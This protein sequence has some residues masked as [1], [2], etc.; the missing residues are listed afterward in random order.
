MR[1]HDL[2]YLHPD[3]AFTTPCAAAGS[4]FWLAARQWIAQGRPLVAA[5]QPAGGGPFCLGLALPLHQ[6]R[7]R[8]GI[9]AEAGQIADVRAPLAVGQCVH[10]L[11]PPTGDRLLALAKTIA[12]SGARLGVYGS[13]AWEALSGEAYRHTESDIDL[14]CDVADYAQYAWAL[15]AFRDAAAELPCR[16]DGELRFP[17]GDAVAWAELAGQPTRGKAVLIKGEREVALKPLHT[18]LAGL[19]PTALAA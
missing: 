10:R 12:A 4:P 19:A 3:A 17:N 5:R 6:E 13:L 14:I 2:V 16:L 1:R 11:A 7:K 9:L 15:A 8:L 18:L